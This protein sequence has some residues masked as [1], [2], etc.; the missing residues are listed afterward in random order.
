MLV[1]FRLLNVIALAHKSKFMLLEFPQGNVLTNRK[2]SLEMPLFNERLH[3]YFTNVSIEG[4]ISYEF[5]RQ[6]DSK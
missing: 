4:R 5:T 2:C 3:L 6:S 1:N